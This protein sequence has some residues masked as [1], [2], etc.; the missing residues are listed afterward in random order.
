MIS[1]FLQIKASQQM[2]LWLRLE[3]ILGIISVLKITH[4]R[5][6]EKSMHIYV[7]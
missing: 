6:L 3:E 1:C 5:R 4:S 2:Q 7:L